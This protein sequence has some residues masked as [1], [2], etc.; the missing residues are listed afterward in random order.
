MTERGRGRYPP[1]TE[2]G[3]AAEGGPKIFLAFFFL[4]FRVFYTGI[5]RYLPLTER[6]Q[7]YGGMGGV[8]TE[9]GREKV[10]NNAHR[11]WVLATT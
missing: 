6:A 10:S 8:R 9:R 3:R 2:R 7:R 5:G 11:C 1:L 4:V